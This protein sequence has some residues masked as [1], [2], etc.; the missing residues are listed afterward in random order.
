MD[1]K[2]P[3]GH[4]VGKLE[5]KSLDAAQKA[6]VLVSERFGA[7]HTINNEVLMNRVLTG[8]V[9]TTELSVA[10]DIVA[11]FQKAVGTLREGMRTMETDRASVKTL[12]DFKRIIPSDLALRVEHNEPL[13]AAMSRNLVNATALGVALEKEVEARGAFLDLARACLNDGS[14]SQQLFLQ[15]R[16]PIEFV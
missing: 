16:H 2:K 14:I 1:V 7:R 6:W 8:E 12:N 11:S 10:K 13:Y 4:V 9:S 3:V 15:L 5:Q